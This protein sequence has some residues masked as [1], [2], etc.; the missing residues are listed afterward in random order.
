MSAREKH[1]NANDLNLGLEHKFPEQ[2]PELALLGEAVSHLSDISVALHGVAFDLEQIRRELE[3]APGDHPYAK[4]LDDPRR[5]VWG[6]AVICATLALISFACV[7]SVLV[8]VLITI[9]LA[10][11]LEI[12]ERKLER[13][14]EK[15]EL[16]VPPWV[17]RP[18][19]P[20]KRLK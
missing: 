6:F 16:Y 19:P 9:R 8:A 14:E 15:Q 20:L 17:N 5:M 2:F 18:R 3:E 12:T 11:K 10:N 1:T 4:G 7:I 13:L